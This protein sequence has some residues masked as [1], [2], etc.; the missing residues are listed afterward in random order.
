[1]AFLEPYRLY[2]RRITV[3]PGSDYGPVG[4]N[5]AVARVGERQP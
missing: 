1:M 3:R 5:V 2:G 4:N